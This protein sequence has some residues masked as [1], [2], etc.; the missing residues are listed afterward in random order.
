[1]AD[2]EYLES[3]RES[4]FNDCKIHLTNSLSVTKRA[5]FANQMQAVLVNSCNVFKVSRLICL[6]AFRF[7]KKRSLILIS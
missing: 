2:K 1:M 5:V 7:I 4:C 3:N 6:Y